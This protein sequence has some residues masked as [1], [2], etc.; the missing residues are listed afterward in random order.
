MSVVGGWPLSSPSSPP[1]REVDVGAGWAVTAA[2]T[3]GFDDLTTQAG[4]RRQVP[5]GSALYFSLAASRLCPVRVAGAVGSDGLA[6][7]ELLDA[8]GT[9]RSA[10]AELPGAS[11]RWRA[12]HHPSNTVPVDEE[13]QLGVYLDWHPQL[14]ALARSSEI[15]FL[16]SMHPKRQLEVL[17]Q[18]SEAKLVVL[19]TM[20]DFVARN[21][22]DLEQVLQRSDMLLANEAELRALLPESSSSHVE[23]A[24]A[25]RQR[26]CLHTVVVKLGPAGAAVI[27]ADS[28]RSYPATPGPQVLDPTGA[29]DA[30]AGGLLG[31]LAQLG[32]DDTA[33]IEA[34]M[35]DGGAAARAAISAFGVEGLLTRWR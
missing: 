14:P 4:R 17:E 13:Q 20:R 30:L 10:V 27:G 3:L 31:R 11:Y 15:L 2:G 1:P 26:W 21:R 18:C 7:L 19:D 29:G 16:G 8:A 24:R 35:V 28:V 5:G 6:L 33:A 25:A 22:A 23:L 12:E 32:R 34:G 9:N